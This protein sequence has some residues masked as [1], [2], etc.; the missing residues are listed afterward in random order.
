MHRGNHDG[1]ENCNTVWRIVKL[2][3]SLTYVVSNLKH[4]EYDLW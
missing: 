3:Y 4:L 2:S 1:V